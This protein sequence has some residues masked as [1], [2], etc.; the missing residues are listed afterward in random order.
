MGLLK[1]IFGN[2]H[3]S[4]A[5]LLD[6]EQR[7]ERIV[8]EYGRAIIEA[9]ELN[10]R[11]VAE[12]QESIDENSIKDF[13]NEKAIWYH[14]QNKFDIRL[15]PY[16]K[17]TIKEAIELLLK[18]ETDKTKIEQLKIGLMFLNDFV[19]YSGLE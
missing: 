11:K 4:E 3:I 5:K 7:A 8:N 9:T 1:K 14:L 2:K 19:E 15:L 13:V 12:F 6:K 17:Q 16:D 10:R 18:D